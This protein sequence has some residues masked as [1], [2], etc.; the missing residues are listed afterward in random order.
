MESPYAKLKVVELKE[1]LSAKGLSTKGLKK[2]LVE[3]LEQAM[4]TEINSGLEDTAANTVEDGEAVQSCEEPGEIK[5]DIHDDDYTENVAVDTPED[6]RPVEEVFEP[7]NNYKVVEKYDSIELDY[8]EP[9]AQ[10]I[11]ANDTVI[12]ANDTNDDEQEVTAPQIPQ[13]GTKTGSSIVKISNLVRPFSLDDIQTLLGRFGFVTTFWIDKLRTV[14]FAE[15]E[16][17]EAAEL[18]K[19]QLSGLQWPTGI[20]KQLVVEPSNV[21]TMNAAMNAPVVPIIDNHNTTRPAQTPPTT[22]TGTVLDQLFCKTKC[23][24][25]LYYLPKNKQ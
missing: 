13:I 23:L 19:F 7:V 15:Y 4:N 5:S 18:C 20:G 8:D 1:Q 25:H 24:P 22:M 14:A 16:S 9:M 21:E 2:D 17:V 3:R 10:S 12:E 11:E 6:S